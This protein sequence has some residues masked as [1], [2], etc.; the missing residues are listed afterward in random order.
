MTC[1]ADSLLQFLKFIAF[2]RNERTERVINCILVKVKACKR[3]PNR[4]VAGELYGDV[5]HYLLLVTVLRQEI[6]EQ[7]Y[8]LICRLLCSCAT[9]FLFWS[10]FQN[11]EWSAS[12][13]CTL[14]GHVL[15][16]FGFIDRF[17]VLKL[18]DLLHIR[19]EFL[20]HFGTRGKIIVDNFLFAEAGNH[21]GQS[22]V[23]QR[24]RIIISFVPAKLTVDIVTQQ[25]TKDVSA[26]HAIIVAIRRVLKFLPKSIQFYLRPLRETL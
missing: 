14:L 10:V 25:E 7:V 5:S 17:A 16:S 11:P 3:F 13:L 8:Y 26:G 23:S 12:L 22:L 18:K 19:L 24:P 4:P 20:P 9:K 21:R 1:K 2:L 6:A 15:P